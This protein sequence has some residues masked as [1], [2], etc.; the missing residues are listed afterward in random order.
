MTDERSSTAPEPLDNTNV[1]TAVEPIGPSNLSNHVVPVLPEAARLPSIQGLIPPRLA[2]RPPLDS[3]TL[4]SSASIAGPQGL[5]RPHLPLRSPIPSPLPPAEGVPAPGASRS[6]DTSNSHSDES[7]LSAAAPQAKMAPRRLVPPPKP[8]PI[9]SPAAAANSMGTGTAPRRRPT[10]VPHTAATIRA[11]RI[12]SIGVEDTPPC[13]EF[14]VS[15]AAPEPQPNNYQGEVAL[16][17]LPAFE[18]SEPPELPREEAFAPL[19]AFELSEPPE[20]SQEFE[21]PPLPAFELLETAEEPKEAALP[22]L[23]PYELLGPAEQLPEIELSP[24]PA[25]EARALISSLDEPP[26]FPS[27]AASEPVELNEED[28]SPDSIKP[29]PPEPPSRLVA[30]VEEIL[31]DSIKPEP[32]APPSRLAASASGSAP[33]QAAPPATDNGDL[34]ASGTKRIPPRPPR[35]ILPSTAGETDAP[36]PANENLPAAAT[37][38]TSAADSTDTTSEKPKTEEKPAQRTRRPWW[39]ELFNED[40]SRA[41]SRLSDEQVKREASFIEDSLGVAQGGVLLDLGCGPGYH[42]VELSERGYA[43]VGYDLSLHQLALA[44]DVAQ[45]RHQKLNLMQG[46]MR[47]MAFDAVFDGIYCWNT[48][49]GYF[50]EDKNFAV[51]ERIFK[52]LRPG[53]T[54]LVDVVNRDF[55]TMQQ[56]S[57]VWFEGDSAVCMDDMTVDFIS[58]RLR[59]KR[60][61]MLDDGRTRECPYSIRLYSLHELGKL[62]HDVGFRVAEASGHPSNPGVFLG[63]NAPRIIILAQRP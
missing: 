44:A 17:P 20:Q 61:V 58:S 16:A 28:V 27:K 19:P 2:G 51:A 37:A 39:E 1:A 42:A 29:S 33:P 25:A 60:S 62:L 36:V 10:P 21:L 3:A 53:G 23:P 47:E 18:L 54:F 22:P 15:P 5:M 48:T 4:N 43:V 34:N 30:T 45:E 6:A 32:P 46:D 9:P 63:Q 26:P 8:L 24:L 12:I 7:D 40:F 31:P 11:M 55:V 38:A 56:P 35:R 14:V 41:M 49:F 52:A 59:V 50:E 57:S 13:S